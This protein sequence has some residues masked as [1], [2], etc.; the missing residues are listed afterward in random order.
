MAKETSGL[1][2]E[3]S[4]LYRNFNKIRIAVIRKS[5][6]VKLQIFVNT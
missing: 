3:Y 5:S 6:S 4:S 1:I 2:M